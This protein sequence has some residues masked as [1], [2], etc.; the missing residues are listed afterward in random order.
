MSLYLAHPT[1]ASTAQVVSPA[2]RDRGLSL[3]RAK[4]CEVQVAVLPT[5]VQPGYACYT[6]NLPAFMFA[7]VT[8]RTT[9][10]SN[11]GYP[12]PKVEPLLP[13]KLPSL[14]YDFP[15]KPSDAKIEELR[16]HSSTVD[17]RTKSLT[18]VMTEPTIEAVQHLVA[19]GAN[20]RTRHVI[21]T[22]NIEAMKTVLILRKLL[23]AFLLTHGYPAFRHTTDAQIAR[24]DVCEPVVKKRKVSGSAYMACVSDVN[25]R[26]EDHGDMNEAT[27]RQ[28]PGDY[29]RLSCAKPTKVP[30][31]KWGAVENIPNASG[32]FVPYVKELAVADPI[33]VPTLVSTYFLR[34]LAASTQQMFVVLDSIRSSWGVIETCG[35]GHEI[36]HFCRCVD[37]ALQAQA[38]VYPVYTNSIYEGT[39]I[40]GAGYSVCYRGMS[41]EPVAYEEIQKVVKMSST[42]TRSIESIAHYAHDDDTKT[43]LREAKSTRELSRIIGEMSLDEA[44]KQEILGATYTLC[45]Q[46]KYWSTSPGYIQKSLDYLC[47]Q[48]DIPNDVPMHPRYLFSRDRVELVMSAFGHQAYTF[49]IPNGA[50]CVLENR[51]EPPRNFHVRT[52]ATDSAISDMKY[53]LEHGYITNNMQSLSSKHRDTPLNGRSKKEIWDKLKEM[54]ELCKP[55]T[56]EGK[57]IR[58]VVGTGGDIYD[59]IW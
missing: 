7:T 23:S 43:R 53:V 25:G 8:G 38:A 34:S 47:N 32:L 59:G 20:T 9:L 21:N 12:L 51:D 36:S 4:P 17:G 37:I 46:N 52:I 58:P 1:N 18:F 6:R 13:W 10:I 15:K 57:D 55:Q 22:V 45:Y 14:I 19:T 29:V 49:M 50:K 27:E 39:L 56:D 35:L 2:V 11:Q 3:L 54:Y 16:K 42:H 48:D 5:I 44:Q 40:Y 41:I 30:G 26:L 31:E 24:E 28:Q 33:T